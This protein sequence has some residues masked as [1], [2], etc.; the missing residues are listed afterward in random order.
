[1]A[2]HASQNNERIERK[3]L[4]E[5]S[6]NHDDRNAAW[7]NGDSWGHWKKSGKARDAI[8]AGILK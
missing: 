7:L 8:I 6:A 4:E 2:E 3:P 5:A 1:L